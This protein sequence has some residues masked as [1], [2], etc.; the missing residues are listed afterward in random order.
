M[1]SRNKCHFLC[2]TN[3]QCY[4]Q[5]HDNFIGF[6]FADTCFMRKQSLREWIQ[7]KG[8]YVDLQKSS[9]VYV[10]YVYEHML[11][12][13]ILNCTVSKLCLVTVTYLVHVINIHKKEL[14]KIKL[15]YFISLQLLLFQLYEHTDASSYWTLKSY[16]FC[17][18][19]Y[20]WD[21]HSN[22]REECIIQDA[23]RS[24]NIHH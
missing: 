7:H 22:E 3:I 12:V 6:H 17:I 19:R 10:C 21:T 11:C 2:L 14:Q 18:S 24:K 13:Q 8:G 4:K 15:A 5:I 23:I 16:V 9:Y 20:Y 1:R